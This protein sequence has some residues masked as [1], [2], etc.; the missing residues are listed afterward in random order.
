MR[1][2]LSALAVI[3]LSTCL[4]AHADTTYNFTTI[5]SYSGTM[6]GSITGIGNNLSAFGVTAKDS[7]GKTYVFDSGAGAT[8]QLADYSNW[9]MVGG[10]LTPLEDILL[11]YQD[12]VLNLG[13]IGDFTTGFT[14]EGVQTDYDSNGDDIGVVSTAI[15]FDGPMPVVLDD[16]TFGGI[17]A[18]P[19]PSSLVLLGTG[20]LG[21]IKMR[22]RTA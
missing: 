19:E 8:G 20:L 1:L 16:V 3:L 11:N 7:N 14:Y 15:V 10:V 13:V 22:R 9:V 21:A 4:A 18:T 5:E 12:T 17:A 6:S 2:K